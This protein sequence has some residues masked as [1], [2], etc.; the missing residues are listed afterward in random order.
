MSGKRQIPADLRQAVRERAGGRCEYCLLHEDDVVLAH[1]ADHIIAE[2][3]GGPTTLE[4]RAW[5]CASC[6]RYKGSDLSSFD[7]HSG[8][9]VN[10]FNP[11]TQQWSGILC[12]KGRRYFPAQP[13]GR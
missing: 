13:P 8:R 2:R 7:I 5:A 4:N 3:H 9:I 6:N 1:E 12:C 10:L 11:R